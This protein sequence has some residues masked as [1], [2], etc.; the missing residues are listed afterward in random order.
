MPL[1]D[2]RAQGTRAGR[3]DGCLVQGSRPLRDRW[4]QGTRTGRADGRRTQGS[5]CSFETGGRLEPVPAVRMVAGL[6]AHVPLETGGRREPV[7][8]VRMVAGLKVHA[9]PSR[10]VG[11]RNPCRT[12]GWLPGSRLMPLRDLRAPGTRTG[13]ADGCLVQ[14]SL[15][16]FE[17]YGGR[18]PVPTL[19]CELSG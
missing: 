17:T 6:K 11:A 19:S 2:L 5:R 7:Q 16:P 15:C 13:R 9:A 10:L 14:G 18:E 3:A 12:C 1:R 4:A 8:A